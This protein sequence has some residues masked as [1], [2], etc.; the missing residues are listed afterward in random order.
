LE[1][2]S[3]L[4]TPT[5]QASPSGGAQFEHRYV[6][7]AH[8][9]GA[10][11]SRPTFWGSLI[12]RSHHNLLRPDR[13]TGAGFAIPENCV[14]TLTLRVITVS[15]PLQSFYE[16]A[17]LI[18]TIATCRGIFSSMPYRC[19]LLE[20]PKPRSV[21]AVYRLTAK[22][23]LNMDQVL[24]ISRAAG[25]DI[26]IYDLHAVHLQLIEPLRDK[27]AQYRLIADVGIRMSESRVKGL[28]ALQFPLRGARG[29]PR[30]PTVTRLISPG[31]FATQRSPDFV[32][33]LRFISTA[34]FTIIISNE[35]RSTHVRAR[36]S[37]G[38]R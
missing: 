20:P 24:C 16:E 12:P 23:V 26:V 8:L 38:T 5:F 35:L 36:G 32:R 30:E 18:S 11:F 31:M 34:R 28:R 25:G 6:Q 1:Q 7:K 9:L 33:C 4:T 29:L 19:C 14:A 2:P 10:D 37:A 17:H 3:C 21:T 15:V 27:V 13:S 22:R